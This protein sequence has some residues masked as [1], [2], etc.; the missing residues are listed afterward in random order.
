MFTYSK[1]LWEKYICG[2]YVGS[3]S[4]TVKEAKQMKHEPE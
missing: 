4:S 3:Y 2:L 1:V